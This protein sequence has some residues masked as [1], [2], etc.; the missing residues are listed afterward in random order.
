MSKKNNNDSEIDEVMLMAFIEG[1]A[2]ADISQAIMANPFL[3][4][5]A[6]KIEKAEL[7][8]Q[9][10]LAP[11]SSS[12]QGI[13]MGSIFEGIKLYVAEKIDL[14]GNSIGESN[15]GFAPT[16]A[17]RGG[18]Q[19]DILASPKS[20]YMHYEINNNVIT[21]ECQINQKFD[22]HYDLYITMTAE[23]PFATARLWKENQKLA[24]AKE[25]FSEYKFE[26]IL[27][28]DYL[29]AFHSNEERTLLPDITIPFKP[30]L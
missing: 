1:E 16:M 10:F 28:G 20:T 27:P 25:D 30:I 6:Q 3:L 24:E 15:K 12:K 11:N 29:V 22:E 4:L 19:E 14:L 7:R 2:P 21:L 26:N 18:S 9:M 23:I 5:N 13:N 8:L 17:F